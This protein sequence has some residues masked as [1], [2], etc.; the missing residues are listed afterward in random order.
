MQIVDTTR[1]SLSG[2]TKSSVTME[3]I[4]VNRKGLE[5]PVVNISVGVRWLVV[6]YFNVKRKKD[7]PIHNTI[8]AY[9]GSKNEEENKKYLNNV[10]NLYNSS[11]K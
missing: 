9:Y 4:A 10:L 7:N 11:R 3:Y 1:K 2:R 8:K 5:D 6:K